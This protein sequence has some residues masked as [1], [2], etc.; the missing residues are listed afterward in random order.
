M[1]VSLID[2]LWLV[3]IAFIVNQSVKTIC[4]S[5]CYIRTKGEFDSKI[6]ETIDSMYKDL[7]DLKKE[8]II[9]KQKVYE[10]KEN[11]K[12]SKLTNTTK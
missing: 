7:L 2:I 10:E 3:I 6:K 4:Y 12:K 5:I 1:N 11:R 8:I 9:D